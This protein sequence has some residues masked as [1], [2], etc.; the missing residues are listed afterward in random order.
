MCLSG[1]TQKARLTIGYAL[2]HAVDSLCFHDII[3]VRHHR[4]HSVFIDPKT[5]PIHTSD[6][7]NV[8]KLINWQ[9]WIHPLSKS[10][11]KNRHVFYLFIF[12]RKIAYIGC[13]VLV[14]SVL[15]I[16]PKCHANR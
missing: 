4:F 10:F 13:F 16:R 14:T 2:G 7:E 8:D 5:K 12:V 9:E 11:C 15:G 1:G 3:F 6:P